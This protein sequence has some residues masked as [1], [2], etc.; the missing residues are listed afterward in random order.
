MN[1]NN[2]VSDLSNQLEG[3]LRK[4]LDCHYTDFGVKANDNLASRDWKSPINFALGYKYA[5]SNNSPEVKDAIDYFLGEV[6]YGENIGDIIKNY[7]DYGFD[8][9][10][11]AY[12]HVEDTLKSLQKILF[13]E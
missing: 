12:A 5:K 13:S 1:E 10:K 4:Y 3:I 6:F 9:E 2:K 11:D 8:T 7:E